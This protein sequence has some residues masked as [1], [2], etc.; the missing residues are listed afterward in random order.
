LLKVEGVSSVL[1]EV[2]AP[3]A[4]VCRVARHPNRAMKVLKWMERESIVPTQQT[5][6]DVVITLCQ[7]D[8][9]T[10]AASVLDMLL[11]PSQVESGRIASDSVIIEVC[12]GSLSIVVCFCDW[13]G[14]VCR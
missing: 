9:V 13:F 12:T 14:D 6:E 1:P 8:D 3:L 2:F 7:A 10:N 4:L 5:I 11:N